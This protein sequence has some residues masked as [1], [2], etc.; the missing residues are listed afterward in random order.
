MSAPA[1]S[2]D[3]EEVAFYTR[4]A[5]TWWDEDGPF[6]PLHVLN[7]LRTRW[8]L[9]QVVPGASGPAPLE[10]FEAL[11]V[12]CGGG[13]LAE[14]MAR[15]GARV[16]G[17]DVTERNLA[18]ATLHAERSG[19]A[20]TYR[21]QAAEDLARTGARFDLVL[22]MEVVEHVAD[23]PGFMDAVNSLVR[24]GGH[25]FVATLNRTL[26]GFVIGIVGAEYVARVLPR[27]THQWSRFVRPDEL[28][29]HLARGGIDVVART[30]VRVNPLTRR[31][32]LTD[33]LAVNYMVHGR[34]R[35]TA[36]G[37]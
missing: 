18:I 11:D 12:G 8:I 26:A 13:L 7:R 15:A 33:W 22:N 34:R 24:P 14:A 10:G 30:G 21:H 37:D 17:I 3:P 23:L 9:E 31:M 29:A 35:S 20:V 2:I 5:D 4:L 25:Q 16:T 27:G 19:L 28:A 1:S 32:R 36:V 6:W